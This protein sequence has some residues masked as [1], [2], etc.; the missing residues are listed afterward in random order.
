MEV[1][2][3][4][5]IKDGLYIGD[6]AAGTNLRLLIQLKI[7]HM[8][9]TCA[10]QISYN[11]ENMGIRYLTYNWPENPSN[12]IIFIKEE[13]PKK[14]LL[15]IDN[16]LQKGTG[17]M[18][19]SIKG[20]NRACVAIIIYLMKKYNWSLKKCREYLYT[21]KQDVRITKSFINQLM[22]YEESLIKKN[23]S[24][25]ISDWFNINLKDKDELLMHNTYLNEK[26]F[27]LKKYLMNKR[28]DKGN[29]NNNNEN[30]NENN[31][32]KKTKPHIQWADQINIENF[33]K[34]TLISKTENINDLFFQK[35]VKPITNH[36]KMNPAKSCIKYNFIQKQ[37]NSNNKKIFLKVTEN[38]ERTKSL[39]E[40]G[41]EKIALG[42]NSINNQILKNSFLENDKTFLPRKLSFDK[43][44]SED[45]NIKKKFLNNDENKIIIDTEQ[46]NNNFYFEN[47]KDNI[48]NINKKEN[49]NENEK[50]NIIKILKNNYYP[51]KLNTI[52]EDKKR[53]SISNSED[54]IKNYN[55]NNYINLKEE[56]NQ[57]SI[58]NHLII[59]PKKINNFL[60]DNKYS[61]YLD[62]SNQIKTQKIRPSSA[63]KDKKNMNVK[64][65]RDKK[66]YLGQSDSHKSKENEKDIN[67][68]PRIN[69]K[70]SH[71][72]LNYEYNLNF[73]KN[74][75]FIKAFIDNKE[76]K[77]IMNNSMGFNNR[78]KEKRDLNSLDS[79]TLYFKNNSK[80][81]NAFIFDKF[82]SYNLKS[83]GPI[84]INNNN[85]IAY[86]LSQ[87]ADKNNINIL[88]NN[89][90]FNNIKQDE[91]LLKGINIISE[92]KNN[93]YNHRSLS[94]KRNNSKNKNNF[95]NINSFSPNNE[96]MFGN[97]KRMPSPVSSKFVLMKNNN[98]YS[99][100]HNNRYNNYMP[101]NNINTN[102][103]NKKK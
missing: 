84:K 47:N 66:Y 5:K 86:K 62:N 33:G 37:S 12:N 102:K 59:S 93:R 82:Y 13:L 35:K 78:Y 72:T 23:N 99:G 21:K 27:T 34:N 73:H 74:K 95:N 9:N 44:D 92:K 48:I 4:A 10:N 57:E 75:A 29:N 22:R 11:F 2:N 61:L 79:K 91:L 67:I 28:N 68:I 50:N 87:S 94:A 20:Q 100:I 77:N 42:Q 43:K 90:I 49:K 83:S 26:Q 52:N 19:F 63:R 16:S 80:P 98:N 25:L 53:N 103:L 101:M 36:L 70:N 71:I 69:Q 58:N 31:E 81:K 38:K 17:L 55:Y 56:N 51:D 40:K 41:E 85:N 96:F 8:I 45:S 39:D 14:I 18:I 65:L 60:K 89:K 15:F 3:I 32:S 7:S 88:M 6:R 1:L 30:K 54:I 24:L 97:Q 76:T 64:L 46:K